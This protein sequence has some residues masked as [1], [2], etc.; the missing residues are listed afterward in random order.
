[1]SSPLLVVTFDINIIEMHFVLNIFLKTCYFF[2]VS[3][4]CI[5]SVEKET[6]ERERES[7]IPTHLHC[8]EKQPACIMTMHRSTIT[9]ARTAQH[10]CQGN[11]I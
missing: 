11:Y 2:K 1:M 5:V 4:Q 6:R 9:I 3:L 8:P 10:H 7:F